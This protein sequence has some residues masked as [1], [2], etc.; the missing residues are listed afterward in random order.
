MDCDASHVPPIFTLKCT[1]QR[2]VHRASIVPDQEVSLIFPVKL[3]HVLILSAMPEQAVEEGLTVRMSFNVVDVGSEVDIH[4][5]RLLMALDELVPSHSM[6]Q[7]VNMSEEIGGRQLFRVDNR[8][9]SDIVVI[10]ECFLDFRVK[11]VVGASRRRLAYPRGQC[12]RR[13]LE[14]AIRAR[15]EANILRVGG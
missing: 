15:E 13:Y 1:S 10:E 6:L 12:L 11:I 4:L 14:G 3:D 5:A 7:R 9:R 8:M 2:A